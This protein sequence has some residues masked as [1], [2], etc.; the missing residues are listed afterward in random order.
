[1]I[2]YLEAYREEPSKAQK[3]YEKKKYC[4]NGSDIEHA[5]ETLA[6]LE[7][8]ETA[9]QMYLIEDPT[10]RIEEIKDL[11][12]ELKEA[13]EIIKDLERSIKGGC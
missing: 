4:E 6:V 7:D 2:S 12:I 9:I 1:M 11:I 10:W 8:E 5:L 3:E 13:R